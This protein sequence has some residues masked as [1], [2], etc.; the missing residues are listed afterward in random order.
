M[1]QDVLITG[2]DRKH[3]LQRVLS[4]TVEE[5]RVH[6]NGTLRSIVD[7]GSLLGF[8]RQQRSLPW[9]DDHDV[10]IY[11]KDFA[12]FYHDRSIYDRVVESLELRGLAFSLNYQSEKCAVCGRSTD[13]RSGFYIDIFVWRDGYGAWTRGPKYRG[14]VKGCWR[15]NGGEER[16]GSRNET[17]VHV[18]GDWHMFGWDKVVEKSALLPLRPINS[19]DGVQHL[20][21]PNDPIRVARAVYGNCAQWN[22]GKQEFVMY[23]W[24]SSWCAVIICVLNVLVAWLVWRRIW[25]RRKNSTLPM[26]KIKISLIVCSMTFSFLGVGTCCLYLLSDRLRSGY[27]ALSL[28]IIAVGVLVQI[29]LLSLRACN[30][31]QESEGWKKWSLLLICVKTTIVW[32]LIPFYPIV[33]WSLCMLHQEMS[34]V[35][36]RQHGEQ[37]TLQ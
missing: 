17:M 28:L 10:A 1:A 3:I 6:T 31:E 19:F 13:I 15:E 24:P 37:T 5:L 34:M 2:A 35:S 25:R 12:P 8:I 29:N 14:A 18:T 20:Y 30:V 26:A 23:A 7:A 22:Q 32:S 36:C 9:D 21:V 11:Y 27:A 33:R 4:D 16:A